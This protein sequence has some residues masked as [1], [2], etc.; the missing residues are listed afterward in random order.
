MAYFRTR[1]TCKLVSVGKAKGKDIIG[2]DLDSFGIFQGFFDQNGVLIPEQCINK[3]ELTRDY[4]ISPQ[5]VRI[6]EKYLQN[7]KIIGHSRI[8]LTCKNRLAK[9]VQLALS[10]RC[11]SLDCQ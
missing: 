4:P 6:E 7:R 8:E 11:V 1:R 5:V 9:E 3:V 10:R 2:E